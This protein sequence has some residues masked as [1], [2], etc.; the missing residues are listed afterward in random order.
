MRDTSVQQGRGG[1]H[2]EAADGH[3]GSVVVRD[4][5]PMAG[6]GFQAK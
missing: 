3:V 6:V 2:W 4:A 1:A 5:W